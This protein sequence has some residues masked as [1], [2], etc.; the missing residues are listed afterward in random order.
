MSGKPNGRSRPGGTGIHPINSDDHG[1]DDAKYAM[2]KLN[3]IESKIVCT[4]CIREQFLKSKIRVGGMKAVCSYCKRTRKSLSLSNF[5]NVIDKVFEEHY[6]R[7]GDDDESGG[8]LDYVIK[9][10]GIPIIDAISDAA[11]IASPISS[12]VQ[13]LLAS[14]YQPRYAKDL[15]EPIPYSETSLYQRMLPS[16]AGMRQDWDAFE[17]ELK[18]RARFFNRRGAALLASVFGDIDRLAVREGCELVVTAGPGSKLERLFRARVFQSEAALLEAMKNPEKQLGAP[19]TRVAATGRMNARGISV[20]YGADSIAGAV[21]EV[22]PPVGSDVAVA[23]FDIIK[24]LRLLDLTALPMIQHDNAS[25]FDPLTKKRMQ[26]IVFLQSL[27]ERMTKPVMPDDQD[28]EYLVTQAIADFLSTESN[29]RFDGI[30]FDSVQTA[31]SQNVVLFNHVSITEIPVLPEGTGVTAFRLN[32]YGGEPASS[33]L[34]F[35]NTPVYPQEPKP[36]WCNWTN[37]SHPEQP[38]LR[39]DRNNITIHSV[40]GVVYSSAI[41][42]VV[43]TRR[44]K[45]EDEF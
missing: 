44:K 24:H 31:G 39:L 29:P 3:E 30:I 7:V 22:R 20:F 41:S 27:G 9:Q 40:S 4:G 11:G 18:H 6:V 17:H 34:V 16:D 25:I 15:D 23:A 10:N 1:R 42:P 5:A 2:T 19:P 32:H 37:D 43:V 33:I 28:F 8:L 13:K 35:E 21:A 38:T 36:G 45:D 26:R 14:R 12:D